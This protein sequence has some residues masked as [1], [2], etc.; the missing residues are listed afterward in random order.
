MSFLPFRRS[1]TLVEESVEHRHGDTAILRNRSFR[2]DPMTTTAL[3]RRNPTCLQGTE[4]ERGA[5]QSRFS[6]RGRWYLSPLTSLD[7]S[8]P[9]D[10]AGGD[11]D[12]RQR[13][14]C[15]NVCAVGMGTCDKLRREGFFL[16]MEMGDDTRE[17]WAS[18]L[19]C[20]AA[21]TSSLQILP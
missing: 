15:T 10:V 17:E 2:S 4:K 5:V 6:D 18:K 14:S 1:G 7:S 13:L 12:E 9:S 19:W 8:R 21:A 3:R 16:G 20:K 11:V